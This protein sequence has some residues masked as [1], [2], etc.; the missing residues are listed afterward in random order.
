MGGPTSTNA[1]HSKKRGE[2]ETLYTGPPG[3]LCKADR[4]QSIQFEKPWSRVRKE[5]IELVVHSVL[6]L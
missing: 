1:I 3:V 6:I 4:G 5:V 2:R